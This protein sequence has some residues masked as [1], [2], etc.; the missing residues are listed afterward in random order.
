LADQPSVTHASR[1]HFWGDDD[2][3]VAAKE[4]R[5]VGVITELQDRPPATLVYEVHT[6]TRLRTR[7]RLK[8]EALTKPSTERDVH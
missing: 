4:L 8:Q 2:V 5:R 1:K 6:L 7:S 3:S